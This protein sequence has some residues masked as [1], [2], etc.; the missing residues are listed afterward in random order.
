M[1]HPKGLFIIMSSAKPKRKI[2]LACDACQERNYLTHKNAQV[3][4]ERLEM[5]KYCPKCRSHTLHKETK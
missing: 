5:N 4:R 2:T 3:H 1:S